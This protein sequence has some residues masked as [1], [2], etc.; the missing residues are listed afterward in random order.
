MYMYISGTIVYNMY[1]GPICAKYKLMQLPLFQTM[2]KSYIQIFVKT[3]V[4]FSQIG[5]H[6]DLYHDAAVFI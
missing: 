3:V 6:V 1:D 2:Y 5:S 4:T